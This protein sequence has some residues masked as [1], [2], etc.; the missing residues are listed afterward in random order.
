MRS[1]DEEK[2]RKFA[3]QVAGKLKPIAEKRKVELLGPAVLP[4][5]LLRGYFRWHVMFKGQIT[6][7]FLFDLKDVISDLRR[8][9]TC[10]IAV[11]VDPVNI[12]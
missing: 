7:Q 12:L 6:K 8:N 10:Q 2:V 5:Y 9:R 4:F 3:Q 11:D 1:K